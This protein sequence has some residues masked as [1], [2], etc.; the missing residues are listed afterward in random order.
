MGNASPSGLGHRRTC[1]WHFDVII[2]DEASQCGFDGIPLFYL[3]KKIIVVGDDKQ[4]RP[5]AVGVNRFAVQKLQ[6][7]F[8]FDFEF[9]DT[10]DV[11]RSIF[12]HSK[13]LYQQ[14]RIVL[15]EHFRCMPE[16]IR[17][18]NDLCYSDTPLI[19]LRQYGPNRLPPLEHVLLAVGIEKVQ[20]TGRS[21]DRKLKLLSIESRKCAMTAGTMTRRWAWWCF[22]AKRRLL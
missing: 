2:V 14:S 9:K 11:E 20:I 17:F 3:G 13:R 12:D 15:R 5:D 16:I 18:S 8:L 6:D 21:T 10:F 4:I 19:P 1:S 7:E 22:R